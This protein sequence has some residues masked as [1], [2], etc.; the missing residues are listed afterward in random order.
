MEDDAR[1]DGDR[2]VLE[3]VAQ[4]LSHD[5]SNLLMIAEGSLELA[6]RQHD[7]EHLERTAAILE[8]A[9]ELT[10][11]IVTL[12]QTGEQASDVEPTSLGAVAEQ[13]WR[14]VGHTGATLQVAE[15]ADIEANPGW[16]RLLLENLFQNAVEHGAESSSPPERAELGNSETVDLTVTLGLLQHGDESGFYVADNGSGFPT[17]DLDRPLESGYSTGEEQS[18]LGLAIVRRIADAHGWSITLTESTAGGARIEFADVPIVDADI[19]N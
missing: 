15:S 12:A 13:A 14:S 11:D 10:D 6:R 7:N 1:G 17:D 8:N 3:E 2:D 9:E 19:P 16:L 4:I 5:L 18:G